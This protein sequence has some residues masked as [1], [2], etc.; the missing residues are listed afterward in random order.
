MDIKNFKPKKLTRKNTNDN[1]TGK[2]YASIQVA[3]E[4]N[5]HFEEMLTLYKVNGRYYAVLHG[6]DRLPSY[7]QVLEDKLKVELYKTEMSTILE[8]IMFYEG[9]RYMHLNPFTCLYTFCKLKGLDLEERG[10]L[11]A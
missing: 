9:N 8:G 5:S 1:V 4:G 3:A 10:L 7:K 2:T 11:R 6:M